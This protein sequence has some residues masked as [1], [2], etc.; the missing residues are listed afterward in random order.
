MP[1][2]PENR[3][4]LYPI[5]HIARGQSRGGWE[6]WDFDTSLLPIKIM[7]RVYIE[8]V[9][10]RFR[11]DEFDPHDQGMGPWAVKELKRIK[12][13]IIH[14]FPQIEIDPVTD[15]ITH[16][17]GDQMKRG[18]RLVREIAVCLRIIRPTL[19]RAQFCE[20]QIRD[21]GTFI[22]GKLDIPNPMADVPLNQRLFSIRDED[23]R[24]LQFYAPLFVQAMEQPIWKFRMAVQ[25][26]EA[27]HWQSTDA[28]VRFLL[29]VSALEALF[30][31][32]SRGGQNSG[33]LVAGERI[34]HLIGSS[35]SVY[36][37][38]ELTS[39]QP[40]PSL[41]VSDVIGDIYCLR[42]HIAHGDK[43]PNYY[44]AR[45]GR[46]NFT[47]QILKIE[48]L[49]EAVS[50]ILR[51]S[52]LTILKNGLL[53]HFADQASS[54]AYFGGLRLTKQLIKNRGIREPTCPA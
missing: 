45:T 5:E 52:L 14:R 24:D 16:L 35:A 49:I 37:A 53:C 4:A 39:G 40:D 43:L 26:Y 41:T 6:E 2:L 33:K 46:P 20:G 30:T 10:S 13:V 38:G 47:E 3:F 36:P 34:K 54:E 50:H 42:N 23:V 8:D 11:E 15:T 18:E 31:T 21:D 25:L 27:G 17:D 7:D 19:Q 48:E 32:Q 9:S 12:Y 51:R 28:K 44:W 29:W 1:E 22:H